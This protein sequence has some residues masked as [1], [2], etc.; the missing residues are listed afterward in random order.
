MFDLIKEKA[1]EAK[2]PIIIGVPVIESSL[3]P[4]EI[5]YEACNIETKEEVRIPS[6]EFIH[7][8]M[9]PAIEV[10]IPSPPEFSLYKQ[11]DRL[12]NS[13]MLSNKTAFFKP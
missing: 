3:F 2:H 1:E 6:G 13:I 4:F 12:T 5:K 8:A 11:I 9:V 7:G 10:E